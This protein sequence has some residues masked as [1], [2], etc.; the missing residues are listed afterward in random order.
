MINITSLTILSASLPRSQTDGFLIG[1]QSLG[2][3]GGSCSNVWD[4]DQGDGSNGQK[5]GSC[6]DRDILTVLGIFACVVAATVTHLV[7]CRENIRT[8]PFR[9]KAKK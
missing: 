3:S 8:L 5:A 7:A 1:P 6:L 4:L 2:N 9:L